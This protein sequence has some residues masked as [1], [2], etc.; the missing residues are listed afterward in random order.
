MKSTD[1]N[2]TSN[3][4]KFELTLEKYAKILLLLN[5]NV[6]G[7]TL[8]KYAKILPLL[9]LNIKGLTLE[10]YAKIL[11][12]LKLKYQGIEFA[13]FKRKMFHERCFSSSA[14]M[15]SNTQDIVLNLVILI[16]R[17]IWE[18]RRKKPQMH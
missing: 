13:Q 10:K 12:L 2:Y 15:N 7:L 14:N 8:E 17:F 1:G 6:K 3:L 18:K 16:G 11:P 9:N 4:H 5:L